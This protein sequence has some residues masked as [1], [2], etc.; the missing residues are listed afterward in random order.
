MH[1]AEHM[2]AHFG[3]GIEIAFRGAPDAVSAH[4]VRVTTRQAESDDPACHLVGV[5][6]SE[7]LTDEQYKALGFSPG[8]ERCEQS[9]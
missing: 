6:F 9:A 8:R 2:A 5:R 3:N 1:Y 4:L 7:V